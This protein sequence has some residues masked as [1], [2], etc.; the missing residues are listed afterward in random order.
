MPQ[1][2]EDRNDYRYAKQNR[3][4][5]SILDR[6]VVEKP[7]S[8]TP[9]TA[10]GKASVAPATMIRQTNAQKTLPRYGAQKGSTRLK[11]QS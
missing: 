11:C 5:V 8:M 9:R 7:K 10:T 3:K 2:G 4:C 1:S 6:S